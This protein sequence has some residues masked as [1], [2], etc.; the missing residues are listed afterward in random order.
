MHAYIVTVLKLFSQL[1]IIDERLLT[2]SKIAYVLTCVSRLALGV[3]GYREVQDLR[4]KVKGSTG[5][6]VYKS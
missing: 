1:Y 5:Y 6:S 4:Q 3:A 2:N